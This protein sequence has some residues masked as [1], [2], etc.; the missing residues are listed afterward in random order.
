MTLREIITPSLI[1]PAHV[2]HKVQVASPFTL[3]TQPSG[4]RGR[5]E[6][7]QVMQHSSWQN[8]VIKP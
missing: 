3:I 5:G 6:G 8:Q 1:L 4:R 2:T 7:F